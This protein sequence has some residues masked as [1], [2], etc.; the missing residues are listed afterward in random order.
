MATSP[1]LPEHPHLQNARQA[2]QPQHPQPQSTVPVP[3]ATV[4]EHLV[5]SAALAPSATMPTRQC[6]TEKHSFYRELHAILSGDPTF[7]YKSPVDTLRG[8]EV[9]S[10]VN[11]KDEVVDKEVE[12]EE[13]VKQATGS[14]NGLPSQ[15]HFLTLKG[16]SQPQQSSSG[17]SEAGKGSSDMPLRASSGGTPQSDKEANV[18]ERQQEIE[19]KLIEEETARRVEELVAKRV[20]EELEKRKDEI[21]REVLRRVE[22]AKR[23]ME[24]QLLEELERQRQAELA[25]QKAR[26]AE[27]QLKIVEE[28][29]KIHEE[30]M[31][32]E[33]ERQRQQKE[34]QKMILGKGKSRPKLSFSLKSQD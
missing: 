31:K 27:E 30:R 23:I 1:G 34:E 15:D 26:E 19:E 28:Q 14:S 18:K 9:A 3:P 6:S 13:D 11:P 25:A 2:A 16:S 32:L 17:M 5:A 24:K 4:P 29:R 12:L 21:E 33:Q 22:E 8:L 20:E 7:T 10:R